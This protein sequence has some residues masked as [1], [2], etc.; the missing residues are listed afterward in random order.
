MGLSLLLVSLLLLVGSLSYV[1]SITAHGIEKNI[2]V[3]SNKTLALK[4]P[5]YDL[6]SNFLSVLNESG[7]YAPMNLVILGSDTRAGQGKGFGNVAGA[8]SDTAMLIHLNA[9]RT[10]G[11]IISFPR[12]LWVAMP[13]CTNNQGGSEDK[14]NAIFA[15][16]GPGCTTKGLTALT[17]IPIDHVLVVDF[18]GFQ[19]I[20]DNI[21]G[22]N[23]CLNYPIN[24][25]KA[26]IILP[27]GQQKLNGTQA[28]GL[29]RARYS[30]ADGSDLQ[31]IKRQQAIV[32]L[33]AKQIKASGIVTSPLRLYSLSKVF[34]TALSVDPGLATLPSLAGLAWQVK[35]LSLSQI[36][37]MTVPYLVDS[38]GHYVIDHNLSDPIFQAI[39]NDTAVPGEPAL[40]ITPPVLKPKTQTKS[41]T[42]TPPLDPLANIHHPTRK[43]QVPSATKVAPSGGLCQ[44]PLF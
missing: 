39:I 17:G 7:P 28:L 1:A 20:V 11:T 29:A 41:S 5:K 38:S 32:L 15:Y 26:H 19:K 30:L 2:T 43:S 31:R 24:D 14:F 33:A 16:G 23:V 34:A 18:K 6:P 9:T 4:V 21:G 36:Q 35:N 27:A 22:L 8:R 25:D 13:A 10:R 37:V 3:I 44:H 40:D 12:D 42:A